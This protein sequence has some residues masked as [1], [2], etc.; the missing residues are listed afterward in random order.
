M[1]LLYSYANDTHERRL[2]EIL[3]TE[4]PVAVVSLSC[5]VLPE[6]REYE[7]A[8]TVMSGPTAGALDAALIAGQGGVHVD[9][10]CDGGGT[11]TDV[12]VIHDGVPSPPRTARW[13]LFRRRSR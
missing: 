13:V 4:Y 8:M 5:G 9:G 3:Q 10:T 2:A 1:W 7:R 11:S 12:S 6:Y